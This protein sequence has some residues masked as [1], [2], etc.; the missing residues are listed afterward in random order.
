[1]ANNQTIV[2][3]MITTT[4]NKY[5]PVTQFDQW[6]AEDRRLGYYT[7]EYLARIARTSPEFTGLETLNETT[8]AID[9]II[10][11]NGDDV[12]KKIPIYA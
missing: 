3:Y 11:I 6:Y 5:D 9:E 7:C 4:D 1:M 12:Y 10:R 2:G 8:R